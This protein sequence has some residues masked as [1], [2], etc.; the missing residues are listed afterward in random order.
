VACHKTIQE[1]CL[2]ACDNQK[3][4][5]GCGGTVLN[6]LVQ[7]LGNITNPRCQRVRRRR[8]CS[9]SYSKYYRSSHARVVSEA[10]YSRR[11]RLGTV[12]TRDN[13]HESSNA[14]TTVTP[15]A[16]AQITCNV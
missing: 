5:E 1:L 6:C 4:P 9:P 13:S 10:R 14:E 12:L 15:A 2:D 16:Q 7:N 8:S 3:D 11:A